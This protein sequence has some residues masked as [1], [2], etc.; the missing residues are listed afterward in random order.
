MEP[1]LAVAGATV[2]DPDCLMDVGASTRIPDR[3]YDRFTARFG[4]H[5]AVRR[6]IVVG[7]T[8]ALAGCSAAEFYWQGVS[9]QFDLLS[10]ARP[11]PEVVRDMP[12]GTLK[13]KLAQVQALRAF[14]TRELGLPEN[15]SYTRYADVGRPYV[16]WNVF[17][18]PQFSLAARQWCFPVAGCVA[19]RG[20]FAEADA[21]AEA[22]R[23]AAEGYDVHVG[24]VPAYSTLG[25]FDDPVLSTFIRYRDAELARLVFH[26]LAHQL[27][28]VK[29]DT[30]FN[31]SFAVAVE[32]AGLARWQ[33]A[34]QGSPDSAQFAADVARIQRMRNDFRS[35]VRTTRD[36]LSKL[37][38]SDVSGNEKLARKAA[39]FADM[40]MEHERIKAESNGTVVFD[41]WFAGGANNAGIISAGLY[42]DR[43]PQFAALLAEEHGDLPRFYDRVRALAAMPKIERDHALATLGNPQPPTTVAAPRL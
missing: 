14:A 18:A 3:S 43:V 6:M 17:A 2:I 42:A 9:G 11:I 26:E 25:W 13:T 31:E 12:D 27:V 7:L 30:S 1:C 40:R 28:Y 41:R 38:A 29:D 20:Y 37:Y 23:L 34:Q 10:R 19:Y 21:R 4:R 39:I 24:G 32:E 8:L 16:V 5:R 22:D 35:M 36:R 15:G 33:L